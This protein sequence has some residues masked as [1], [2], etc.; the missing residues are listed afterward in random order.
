MPIRKRRAPVTQARAAASAAAAE[1]L[2]GLIRAGE[3]EARQIIGAVKVLLGHADLAPEDAERCINLLMAISKGE[4]GGK[5]RPT[6]MLSA[7]RMLIAMGDR[8][9]SQAAAEVD[10]SLPQ[11]DLTFAGDELTRYIEEPVYQSWH[12]RTKKPV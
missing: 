4:Y 5:T 2:V 9:R 10:A 1:A 7:S 6:D 8:P 12:A 11:I 3:V